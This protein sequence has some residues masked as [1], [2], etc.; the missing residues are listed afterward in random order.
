[1][2]V[3]VDYAHHWL[4]LRWIGNGTRW[5][6]L[7]SR[8]NE[9]G[10]FI[11]PWAVAVTRAGA[12]VVTDWERVQVLTVDGAVLCVLDPTVLGFSSLGRTLHGV[13]VC[14]RTDEIFITEY[15]EHTVVALMWTPPSNVRHSVIPI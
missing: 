3:V 2:V 13:A 14:A 12:L 8:G 11:C 15:Y 5:K 4:D 1:M 6:H 7:G 9:P 10:Q